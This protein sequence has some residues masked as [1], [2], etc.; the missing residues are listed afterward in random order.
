MFLLLFQFKSSGI[1]L[2]VFTFLINQLFMRSP[3]NDMTMFK[4][5][6]NIRILYG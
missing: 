4:D 5:H 6:D 2:I 3:F 1:E